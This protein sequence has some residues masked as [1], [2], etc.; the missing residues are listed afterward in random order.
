MTPD[1]NRQGPLLASNPSLAPPGWGSAHSPRSSDNYQASNRSVSYPQRMAV[2]PAPSPY[3]NPMELADRSMHNRGSHVSTRQVIGPQ[4]WSQAHIPAH[5]EHSPLMPLSAI[6]SDS[7]ESSYPVGTIESFISSSFPPGTPDWERRRQYLREILTSSWRL[8]NEQEPN[9]DILLRLM[10]KING[11]WD[12]GFYENGVK[13][14]SCSATRRI[15]AVEHV[16]R[17]IDLLPF[18]CEGEPW[19][20]LVS[21]LLKSIV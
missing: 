10:D 20:V 14:S 8:R 17:H 5:E 16:R 7:G 18:A 1:S 13:C 4:D 6:S 15:Q 9:P 21:N 12:C 19:Y 2:Q 3:Y 11:V